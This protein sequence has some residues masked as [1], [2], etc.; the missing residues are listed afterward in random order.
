MY[1]WSWISDPPAWNAANQTACQ[2]FFFGKS[3]GH[4]CRPTGAGCQVPG[5]GSSAS[6]RGA[7][8]YTTTRFSKGRCDEICRGNAE[9]VGAPG[10]STTRLRDCVEGTESGRLNRTKLDRL[11][12]NFGYSAAPSVQRKALRITQD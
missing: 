5:A 1:W 3:F 4:S 2:T 8:G 7:P 12:W 10:A 9:R 11:H 6:F